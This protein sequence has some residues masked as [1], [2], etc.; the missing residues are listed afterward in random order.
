MNYS[1][2]VFCLCIVYFTRM[3]ILQQS[4]RVIQR[5]RLD[6]TRNHRQIVQMTQIDRER[7]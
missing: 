3:S 7:C 2:A 5:V 4:R 1:F 6:T